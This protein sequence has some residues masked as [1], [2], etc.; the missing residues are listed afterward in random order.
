MMG[1]IPFL[2]TGPL[3][4]L[5][6]RLPRFRFLQALRRGRLGTPTPA[7]LGLALVLLLSMAPRPLLAAEAS[8][9]AFSPAQQAEIGRLVHD[10]ILAH[11]E[12]VLQAVENYRNRQQLVAQNHLESLIAANKKFLRDDP[13]SYVAGNPKGDVTIVE[14]FDYQCPYCKQMVPV[15]DRLLK[16]DGHIRLVLKEYP[17]L[18]PQSVY[19]SRAAVA[20]LAQHRYGPFH[21]E[22]MA[23]HGSLSAASVMDM[24]GQAGLDVAKLKSDMGADK[25]TQ[26]LRANLALGERLGINGTPAFLIGDELVPG[27]IDGEQLRALVQAARASCRTC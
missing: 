23:H 1:P 20:A 19:A 7:A 21:D 2:L 13:L 5:S 27:A 8:S 3:M 25:V 6:L 10:Y 26:E 11:P 15:I 12:V 9:P 24:A 4:R 14:F 18:G 17:V 22:M 16:A